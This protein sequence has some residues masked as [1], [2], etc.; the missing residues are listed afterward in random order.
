M[1]GKITFYVLAELLVE[2]LLCAS[3]PIFQGVT[4]E[5]S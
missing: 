5:A 2:A 1:K 4:D 3:P